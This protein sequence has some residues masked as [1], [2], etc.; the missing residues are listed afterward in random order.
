MDYIYYRIIMKRTS[1]LLTLVFCLFLFGITSTFASDT[2]I[3]E[4]DVVANGGG[5]NDIISIQVPDKH[6]YGQI[7]KGEKSDEF[8][9]YVNNTGTVDITVTPRITDI[10]EEIFSYLY[11]RKTKTRTVN[12]TSQDVAF[13]RVGDFSFNITKPS[14]GNDYNDEYFYTILDLTDYPDDV[15]DDIINHRANLKFYAVAR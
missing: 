13:T 4:V 15:D 10:G 9:I 6:D 8:K 7:K 14:G 12:G 5:G 11:F 2:M 3:V 1:W